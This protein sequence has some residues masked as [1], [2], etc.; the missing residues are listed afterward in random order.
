MGKQVLLSVSVV[1][2]TANKCPAIPMV[3]VYE[4]IPAIPMV[5]VYETI[6]AIPMVD[7][8]ETIY[9]LLSMQSRLLNMVR[10]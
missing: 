1:G 5:D 3:G 8:Y 2:I 7:V 9:I 4:T 10:M 6:P